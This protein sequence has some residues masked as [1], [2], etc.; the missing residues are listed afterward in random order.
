[1]PVVA[2]RTNADLAAQDI[3]VPDTPHNKLFLDMIIRMLDFDPD[4]RLTVN[5][6][7]QHPYLVS[8]TAASL[9]HESNEGCVSV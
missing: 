5:Q 2:D 3:I 4:M 6:A 7:L 1:V 9:C 8:I